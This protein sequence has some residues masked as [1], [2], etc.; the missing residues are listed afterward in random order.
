MKIKSEERVCVHCG[1]EEGMQNESHQLPV[2]KV[3]K[4]Q[5]LIGRVLGQG[6]FGITYLGWDLYLDIPVAIKEYFPDR[7]VMREAAVSSAVVSYTGTVGERFRSNKERFMREAKMLAKFSD[8]AEIVQVKNFFLEN[9]TAYIVM[10][11]VDGITLK[12]YVAAKGGKLTVAETLSLMEPV[13]DALG[14]VHK[15]G[16]VHRDISPD[17]IMM[18]SNGKMKL[19]DFGAVRDVGDADAE[20][21]LTRST[22]A[23]LKQGYAPIEQYQNRGSL[24]PWTDVYAL[25]ATMYFCLTGEV[26]P[27]AP[28]RLLGEEEI[29]FKGKIPGLTNGQ[30]AVFRHGMQLRAQKR[31]PSMDELHQKLYETVATVAKEKPEQK[32]EKTEK[33]TEKKPVPDKKGGNFKW[34]A[35]AGVVLLAV[36]LGVGVLGKGGG[37]VSTETQAVAEDMTWTLENGVLTITGEGDMPDYNGFWMEEYPEEYREGREYA[38]WADRMGEIE[39]VVLSE[40][41][42]SV[43]DNAFIGAENLKEV[44]WSPALHR[45]GWNAFHSTGL[46]QVLLPD[47]VE[48]I[49]YNAFE[50]CSHLKHVELPYRLSELRVGTF[51]NCESLENV[52]IRPYTSMETNAEQ[53]GQVYTPFGY[54]GENGYERRDFTIHTY[55]E[56]P[57]NDF[58]EEYHIYHEYLCEGW[59]GEDVRWVFDRETNTL[60]LEG[61]GQS[62]V[63]SLPEEELDTWREEFSG[64]WL[65]CEMPDWWYSF[66]EDIETIVVGD[67]I[68]HLNWALFSELPNLKNVD[69]GNVEMIDC[70]FRW[71]SGLE[72]IVVPETVTHI[73]ACSFIGCENLK[74]VEFLADDA[75]LYWDVFNGAESLEEV[76]FGKNAKPDREDTDLRIDENTMLYV[77]KN[78]GM[79]QYALD[80]GHEFV[81]VESE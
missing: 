54:Y 61:T 57:A 2:G 44:E 80:V 11:Y 78:S 76:H 56:C 33:K 10:E 47:T 68:T 41:I 23:I 48:V 70:L 66:R 18:L 79:H 22:E 50:E 24:G 13:I 77:H 63:Y 65:Y 8:V 4:E 28:E 36:A 45:I 5:Y 27:D 72:E 40:G 64:H 35:I 21:P 51:M 30:A 49:E 16:L 6:G 46:E 19:L 53:D 37:N 39:Y 58:A 15:T 9:N 42:T 59:C 17:N 38:P 32:A 12:Q 43:G 3:L 73:G 81:I 74:K 31:L 25:C 20:R 55:K 62:W 1:Y 60:T 34:I 7:A 69:L 75:V 52:V 29:D 67:G 71:C 26:P 14:Q